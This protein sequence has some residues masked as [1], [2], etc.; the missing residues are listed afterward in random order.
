MAR[1]WRYV[2]SGILLDS[3]EHRFLLRLIDN[4]AAEKI[5]LATVVDPDP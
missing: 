4:H 3:G 2:E 1:A 5:V